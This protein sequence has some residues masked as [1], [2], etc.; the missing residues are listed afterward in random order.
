MT[1]SVNYLLKLKFYNKDKI[2]KEINSN[3]VKAVS[4]GFLLPLAA[5]AIGIIA[6]GLRHRHDK[7]LAKREGMD[8]SRK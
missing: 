3:Q 1:L 6:D 7:D 2:M 5:I 8:P 4:G